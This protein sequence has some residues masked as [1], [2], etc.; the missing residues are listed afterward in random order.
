MNGVGVNE[1]KEGGGG[2]ENECGGCGSGLIGRD[3]IS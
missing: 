2:R 3:S 1:A